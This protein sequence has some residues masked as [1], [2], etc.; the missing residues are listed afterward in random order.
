MI[1]KILLIILGIICLLGIG[2]CF[3]LLFCLLAIDDIIAPP[4][5]PNYFERQKE[6][7]KDE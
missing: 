6:K 1:I 4:K 7:Y 3:G 2:F 5:F